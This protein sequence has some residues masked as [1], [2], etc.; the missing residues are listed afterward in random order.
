MQVIGQLTPIEKELMTKK[1]EELE[2]SLLPGFNIY[3]WNSLGIPEFIQ[4][5]NKAINTFQQ[6]VKQVQKNSGIIEQVVYSI[7]GSRI[8]K[9]PE[10]EEVMDLQEFHEHIEKHRLEAVEKLVKKYRTIA[11]LLGKIEEVVAGTNTGKSP[12]LLS[13]YG[14]WE[15]AIFNSLNAMVLNA[16]ETLQSMIDSRSKKNIAEKGVKKPP[17]FKITFSLQ[18]VEI[19]IQPPMNE[20][21]KA[22]GRL[23]RSLVESTK[24]FVRWMDGTCIETPEQKGTNEDDEPVVFTFY[25]DVAANPQVSFVL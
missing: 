19:V 25:W 20:V 7:A 15:R 13:Y 23:V 3:N 18:N 11:P 22:L 17:L 4:A 14:Y 5:C 8:V 10:G 12:V 24:S 16:M 2:S 9:E 21:N 6:V 1:L